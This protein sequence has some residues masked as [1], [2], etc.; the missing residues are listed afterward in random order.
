MKGAA[1]K[2]GTFGLILTG[3]G[4]TTPFY[5][6][7]SKLLSRNLADEGYVEIAGNPVPP[8]GNLFIRDMAQTLTL[9]PLPN[10]PLAGHPITL[11]C[12]VKTFLL[13]ENVTS[14]PAFNSPQRTHQW[15]VTG[16]TKSGTFQLS[17]SGEGMTTPILLNISKLLSNNLSH[18]ADVTINGAPVPPSGNTFLHG[19]PQVLSI[20]PKPNSPLSGHPVLLGCDIVTD[21]ITNVT[22]SPPVKTFQTEYTWEVTAEGTRGYFMLGL[23]AK[24]TTTPLVLNFCKLL[25]SEQNS[26]SSAT[27]TIAADFVQLKPPKEL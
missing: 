27:N 6:T 16:A 14:N 18:E 13:P 5:I 4:M 23:L 19:Q 12:A 11:K 8:E 21:H 20:K 15:D 2:S 7:V 10:S 1:T 3:E 25:S 26:D 24:G 22:S 17:L 9:K